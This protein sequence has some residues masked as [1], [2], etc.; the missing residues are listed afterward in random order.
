MADC[1]HRSLTE[2]LCRRLETMA[3]YTG[4]KHKVSRREGVNLTGT[5]SP[6]LEKRLSLP[7]GGRRHVRKRASVYADRL[8]AKQRVKRQYGLLERQFRRF[9]EAAR[10]MSGPTGENLLQLLE[11]RLDNT[12]YRLRF[13]RTRPM[14]R[15]MVNHGRVLVNNRKVDIPS[16]I[17]KPGDVIKLTPAALKN[18]VVQD[19][20]EM[21]RALIPSWLARDGTTGQVLGLPQRQHSDADIREDLIVEFYAR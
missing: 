21:P 3:R 7:P 9:F 12:V 19:E 11:R 18:P 10:K 14:A 16:Y 1:G 15:Q 17:V 4:P 20:L 5:T 2:A 6:S 13:A 8:R